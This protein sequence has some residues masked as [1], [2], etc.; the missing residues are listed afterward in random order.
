MEIWKQIE[1]YPGYEAS[2]FGRVRR[3]HRWANKDGI[4]TYT[5][6]KPNKLY[7]KNYYMMRMSKNAKQYTFLLHRLIARTF[8][9]NPNNLPI[10]MHLDNDG[11]NNRVD[12]LKWSTTSENTQAAWDEGL[13]A[14]KYKTKNNKQL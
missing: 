8:L 9:D 3:W 14:R 4:I 12:N 2:N 7:K 13:I 10:V 1:D 11:F 6:L 5:L